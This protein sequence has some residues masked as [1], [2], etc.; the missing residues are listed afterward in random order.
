MKGVVDKT[1]GNYLFSIITFLLVKK[2]FK[3]PSAVEDGAVSLLLELKPDG[4]GHRGWRRDRTLSESLTRM[5][6]YLHSLILRTIIMCV[7]G[8][9]PAGQ[10]QVGH[11]DM[12]HHGAEPRWC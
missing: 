6:W 1:F 3:E 9:M 5:Q 10:E 12:A 4:S 7:T 8:K 11:E 2:L